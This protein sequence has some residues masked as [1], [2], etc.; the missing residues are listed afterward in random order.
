MSVLKAAAFAVVIIYLLVMLF[1]YLLQTRLIF[2]PGKLEADFKFKPDLNATELFLTTTD[3][4]QINALFFEGSRKDVILYFHGNAGDL[5]GWQYVAEDFTS[6]GY[7]FM[8]IDYR[9]Y[10]KSEGVVSEKGLYADAM[11]AFDVLIKKN[12]APENIIIYGRSV[13][14]GVAVDLAARKNCK[15]LILEAPFASLAKLADEKLPFLFPSLFIQYRFDN[16]EKINRVTCPVVFIHGSR[17]T[18][19]PSSHTDTLFGKYRG[20][21]KKVIL[22]LAS[23]NDIN[24]FEEYRQFLEHG[25]P[26]FFADAPDD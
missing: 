23:H 22:T 4:V 13:G 24:D 9:G 18:L 14:S 6:L 11:A 21:K 15:G 17:D 1:L 12:F 8:I 19:I 3:G 7:H 20:K 16:L 10:G 2:Y 5:S 26:P 25:L